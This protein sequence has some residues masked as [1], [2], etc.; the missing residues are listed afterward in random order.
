[1]SRPEV[2]GVA[3]TAR[4]KRNP[5]ADKAQPKATPASTNC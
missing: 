3:L 1:M 2:M 5:V 4:L